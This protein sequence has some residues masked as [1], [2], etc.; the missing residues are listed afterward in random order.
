MNLL[1]VAT[2]LS[3]IH[4]DAP[5]AR[6]VGHLCTALCTLGH[7]VTVCAPA[8]GSAGLERFSFARRLTPVVVDFPR[9]RIAFHVLDGRLPSGV[10][11][12]LLVNDAL[13]EAGGAQG[14]GDQP[15]WHAAL[16][17]AAIDLA[18]AEPVDWHVVHGVSLAGALLPL[19]AS[20]S[21]RLAG[22]K[23]LLFLDGLVDQ[24]R[25]SREWV[26]RLGL[27]WEGFTP[28]GYE[29]F[30]DLNVLKA[31]LVSA[32]SLVL[33][34]HAR[35]AESLTSEGAAG[36]EGVMRHRALDLVALPPGLDFARW[37]PATDPAL[38]ARYDAGQ[39]DGK[40]ICKADFQHRHGLPVQAGV[41]L[42][43]LV[44]PLTDMARTLARI[45]DRLL[46]CELQ[47]VVPE[48]LDPAVDGAIPELLERWPRQV[49]RVAHGEPELH[50]LL[51]AADV[52]VLDAPLRSDA[53]TLL[54]ALRYGALPVVRSSGLARDLV[55]DLE[56]G[57]E[58][59]NGFVVHEDDPNELLAVILRATASMRRETVF[60]ELVSRVMGSPRSW[61]AVAGQ[62]EQ[63][64]ARLLSAVHTAA[65]EPCAES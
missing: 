3:P 50:Q 54:A 63:V 52:V 37:N 6:R 35:L 58:S 29:F 53:E 15:L 24:G 36:L 42:V 59:G 43:G 16:C 39:P 47:L 2:E 28:E 20:R 31:G 65:P 41:P 27:G 60:D 7:K 44:P 38:P 64:Y 46:R 12:K 19:L 62:L 55:V 26:E 61:E 57:L 25:C 5:L 56:P 11:V 13:A 4:G 32:D 1:F 14:S 17:R 45:L 21:P 8:A 30:G 34:G 9:D 23:R 49:A 18:A 51:A 10:E 22:A 33:D 48:G 40:A